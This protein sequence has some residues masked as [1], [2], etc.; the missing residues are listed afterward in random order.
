MVAAVQIELRCDDEAL[1]K[2]THVQTDVQRL[3][4]FPL[5]VDAGDA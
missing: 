5:Q 1:G 4:G 3:I 2:E